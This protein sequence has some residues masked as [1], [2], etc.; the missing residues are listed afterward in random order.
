MNI[1]IR[2]WFA[3]LI[4]TDRL[5]GTHLVEREMSRLQQRVAIFEQ[6]AEALRR[7]MKEL[8]QLL[9]VVQV[10]MCVLCLRQRQLLRPD[11]WLRFVPSESAEEEK[12][13]DLMIG[14]L[15]KYGLATVHLEAVG[16]KVYVYYLDPNWDGIVALLST[17]RD[18]LDPVTIEWLDSVR[19]SET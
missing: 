17:W 15:V 13:L 16:E 6:R 9:H 2:L 5:L 14:R 10:E 8:N 12:L 1:W 18:R 4:I 3:L 7:Q 11:D 19:Q